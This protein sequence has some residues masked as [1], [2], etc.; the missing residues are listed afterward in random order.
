[1]HFWIDDQGKRKL[2]KTKIIATLGPAGRDL[3]DKEETLRRNVSYRKLFVWLYEGLGGFPIDII[4]LN[5]SFYP[6]NKRN[7]EDIFHRFLWLF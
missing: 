3:F 4:R 7:C 6:E 2:L 1:M 5:M